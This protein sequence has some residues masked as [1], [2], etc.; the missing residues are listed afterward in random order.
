MKKITRIFVLLL[1]V[2]AAALAVGAQDM[3]LLT[4]RP[5]SNA[6]MN[7]PA[8]IVPTF[9]LTDHDCGE[10]RIRDRKMVVRQFRRMMVSAAPH[11]E[12]ITEKGQGPLLEGDNLWNY[13]PPAASLPTPP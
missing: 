8:L 1:L 3:I 11:S 5:F 9:R 4:L 12:P 10:S 7:N 6:L 2:L 13:D